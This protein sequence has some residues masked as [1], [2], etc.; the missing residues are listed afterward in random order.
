MSPGLR[1]SRSVTSGDTSCQVSGVDNSSVSDDAS[2]M[3]TCNV[4]IGYDQVHQAVEGCWTGPLWRQSASQ[5]AASQLQVL[6]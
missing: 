4:A 3:S 5:A 6:Q 2:M 1:K